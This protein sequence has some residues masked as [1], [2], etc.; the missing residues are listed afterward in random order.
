[1]AENYN[2]KVEPRARLLG[3]GMQT[4]P[5]YIAKLQSEYE[6]NARLPSK[7]P[8]KKFHEVLSDKQQS[9]NKD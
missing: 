2:G 4:D 7:P 6:K 1:M 5:E 9:S 8:K 3:T